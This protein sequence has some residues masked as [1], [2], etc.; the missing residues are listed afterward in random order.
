[1]RI[2][3]WVWCN[4]SGM[5]RA[6]ETMAA[7]EKAAG[8][9]SVL[10]NVMGDAALWDTVL[11]ADVHVCHTHIPDVFRRKAKAGH[12][13]VYVVHGTPEHVFKSAVEEGS[14]KSYGHADGWQLCQNWL[15][16]ADA[17]V[18]F[19]PRH[20]ALWKQMSDKRTKVE[21][22]PLGVDKTF[23][24][25]MPT[26][27]K[28]AGSPSLFTAENCHDIKWPLDLFIAWPWVWD[29]INPDA[30]LHSVYLPNDQHRWFFPLVNRNGCSYASHITGMSFNH[31]QLRNAFCS[32]DYY[33]GL[34]RYGDFNRVSL[35]ANACGT[36]TIS[37]AGNIYSDY[38]VPEGDQRVIADALVD[39]LTGKVE[40]RQKAAV[41]DMSETAAGMKAVYESL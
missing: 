32:V 35:E 1:M 12:K 13:V 17:T 10:V 25:P 3:H 9:D 26:Q 40:P 4:N 8:L 27:G 7:A 34:V 30:R 20:Q 36:K 6:A 31:E 23:W 41:P 11:D 29:R 16:T 33:I 21:C 39:I 37:Y 14:K 28:Y 22:V 24:K 19:W 5:H 38:W 2:A 18:T 15:R